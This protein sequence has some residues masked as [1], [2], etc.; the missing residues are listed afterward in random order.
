MTKFPLSRNK[1]IVQQELKDGLL[2]YDLVINKAYHLN[3]TSAAIYRLCDGNNS[4][5]DIKKSIGRELKQPVSEDLVWLALDQL[6]EDNLLTEKKEIKTYFNGLSRR[7]VIK[8]VGL[9]SMIALPLITP[10][11]APKAVEAQSCTA[12]GGTCS[13]GKDCCTNLCDLNGGSPICCTIAP[14]PFQCPA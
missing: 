6:K 3:E 8:K 9:A 11:V 5:S 10:L 13:N 7:E 4:I 14:G 2:I 12:A 1:D